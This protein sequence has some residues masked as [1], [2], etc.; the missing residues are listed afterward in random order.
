MYGQRLLGVVLLSLQALA[1]AQDGNQ[2]TSSAQLVPRRGPPADQLAK[3]IRNGRTFPIDVDAKSRLEAVSGVDST[4]TYT[5]S[6]KAPPT[7]SD[8]IASLRL[9]LRRGLELSACDTP[10]FQT[11]LNAG[12]TLVIV[13]AFNPPEPDLVVTLKPTPKCSTE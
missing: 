7:R 2:S 13:Y 9:T 10:N 12:Y 1:S 3:V 8:D 5:Y 6:L 11:L 4:L